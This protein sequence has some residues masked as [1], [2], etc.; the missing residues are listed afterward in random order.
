MASSIGGSKGSTSRQPNK[1]DKLGV[2][3]GARRARVMQLLFMQGMLALALL[4]FAFVSR[5]D[6]RLFAWS[7]W[8]LV[9]PAG[10][11]SVYFHVYQRHEAASKAGTWSPEF[12]KNEDRRGYS[13]LGMVF[14]TWIL[15]TLA[16]FF[17]L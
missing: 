7:L 4:V 15:G 14:L 9:V 3:R 13:L 6:R 1:A 8:M 10:I 2:G 17:L 11:G 16:I 12:S 5:H